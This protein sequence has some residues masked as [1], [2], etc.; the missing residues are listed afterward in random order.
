MKACLLFWTFSIIV[1]FCTSVAS[2]TVFISVLTYKY[3]YP[4]DYLL[5][6]TLSEGST[7]VANFMHDDGNRDC[8]TLRLEETKMM[9]DVHKVNFINYKFLGKKIHKKI[10]GSDK[11][12]V[13]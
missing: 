11:N 9:T 7:L 5:I 3:S 4:V 2:G 6:P 8:I 13:D 1:D 10:C 12:E